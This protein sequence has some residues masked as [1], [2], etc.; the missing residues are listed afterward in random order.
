MDLSKVEMVKA[1]R[2]AGWT[3]RLHTVIKLRRYSIAEHSWNM[4]NL[5]Q[6]LF[7]EDV[8]LNLVLAIQHHD[9]PERWV[10]DIPYPSKRN[11]TDG[12]LGRLSAKAEAKV[13]EAIG[14]PDIQLTPR[15]GEILGLLDVLELVLWASEEIKMGN[16]HMEGTF[17]N[18]LAAVK[19]MPIVAELGSG[20]LQDVAIKNGT[21]FSPWWRTI[22]RRDK[23]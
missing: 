6:I 5:L 15:E 2:E 10:G 8:T 16:S 11:L 22:M 4:V 12:E 3:D 23:K 7:P 21:E 18:G 14:L 19:S 9:M 17:R 1:W 13:A 20:F